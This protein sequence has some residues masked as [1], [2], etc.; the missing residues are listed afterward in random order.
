ML[1]EFEL[2]MQCLMAALQH[3]N[4]HANAQEILA[5]ANAFVDFV[6]NN[7]PHAGTEQ[8]IN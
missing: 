1:G 3:S 7:V 4:C 6:T 2:R 8:P 5:T